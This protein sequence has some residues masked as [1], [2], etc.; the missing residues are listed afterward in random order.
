MWEQWNDTAEKKR[1]KQ[2]IHTTMINI[3][4]I[5]LIKRSQEQKT[6]YVPFYLYKTF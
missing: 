5:M 1:S 4:C 3:K 6:T 2:L